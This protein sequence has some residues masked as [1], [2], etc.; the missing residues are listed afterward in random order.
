MKESL[1]NPLSHHPVVEGEMLDQFLRRIGI[2]VSESPD[3]RSGVTIRLDG[4]G[5]F[6]SYGFKKKEDCKV[7]S[8]FLIENEID[9]EFSVSKGARYESHII[10]KK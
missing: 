5:K 10:F 2:P 8:D 6:A 7:M 3:K 1:L 4:T 9:F